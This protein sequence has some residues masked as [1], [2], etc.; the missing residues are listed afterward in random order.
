[1]R[2]D[3]MTTT[4]NISAS[5]RGR[6]NK[7]RG[8]ATEMM[9]MG[10]LRQ[11]GLHMIEKIETGF[12]I[13]RDPRTRKIV[14]AIP[15]EKVAGDFRAIANGGISVLVEAKYRTGKLVYS[16]LLSH[17]ISALAEHGLW[18][19]ISLLAWDT[20]VGIIIMHWPVADF[21]PGRSLTVDQGWARSCAVIP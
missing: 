6:R 14:R 17:Q 20:G 2:P 4:P 18:G 15:T 8:A 21:G 19:G 16:D 3:P 13:V 12:K 9:V 10:R 7:A 5:L 1:M 11:M